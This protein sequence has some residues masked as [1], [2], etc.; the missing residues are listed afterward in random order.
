[1]TETEINMASYLRIREETHAAEETAN[2]PLDIELPHLSDNELLDLTTPGGMADT[3]KQQIQHLSLCPSCFK[4]YIRWQKAAQDAKQLDEDQGESDLENDEFAYGFLK[5]AA[6]KGLT[7]AIEL[8]SQC[9][10][11]TLK[12]MPEIS[13]PDQG[14]VI[15]ESNKYEGVHLTVKDKQ[16]RN[17]IS[18]KLR[19]GSLL[20]KYPG[21][22][23][24]L[25]LGTWL[26]RIKRK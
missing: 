13:T 18:G 10:D 8:H 20:G 21:L 24:E 26:V 7:E 25:D 17:I 12:I 6:G 1:M 9:G 22:L 15:L 4:R 2:S 11:F 19:N 16:G 23:S 3:S 5:A 14:L